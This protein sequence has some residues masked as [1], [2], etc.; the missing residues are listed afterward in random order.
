MKDTNAKIISPAMAALDHV[1][2]TKG[3][4][5]KAAKYL[6]VSPSL[7]TEIKQGRRNIPAKVLN[8]LGMVKVVALVPRSR[9]KAVAHGIKQAAKGGE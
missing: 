8:K 7:V 4:Q 2:S 6:G 9:A 1:I 5:A 3:S